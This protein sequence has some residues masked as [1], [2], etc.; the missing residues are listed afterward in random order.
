MSFEDDFTRQLIYSL[1]RT[2]NEIFEP[3]LDQCERDCSNF[4]YVDGEEGDFGVTRYLLNGEVVFIELNL[5]GDRYDYY[6]SEYAVKN[7]IQPKF[8]FQIDLGYMTMID[9]SPDNCVAKFMVEPHLFTGAKLPVE[10]KC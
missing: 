5:A 3:I 10:R 9:C 8:N 2:L 4:V 7:L 1:E 6:Y